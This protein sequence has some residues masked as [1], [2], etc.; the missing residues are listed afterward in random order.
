MKDKTLSSI[1]PSAGEDTTSDWERVI[2][3]R[4]FLK[5]IGLAG[6]ALPA[7]SL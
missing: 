5:G 1:S 3:R 7:A 4:S 6:A 2:R